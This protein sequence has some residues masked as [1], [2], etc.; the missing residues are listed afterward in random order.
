MPNPDLGPPNAGLS[1]DLDALAAFTNSL[2]YRPNPFRSPDGSLAPEAERGQA[3]FERA[4]VGCTS[5]HAAPFYTDSTFAASPFIVHDVGTGDGPG[6]ALGAA[7]DTPSLLGL[8]DSAP[9]LHDGSAPT[10]RDVLTTKNPDD[11]HGKTSHLPEEEIQDVVAFLLSLEE[12]E[13]RIEDLERL[14]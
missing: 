4:D 5:C 1:E 6:E 9:Y 10:L 14:D 2:Q 7:F 13:S 8:W 11:R 12:A 3:I